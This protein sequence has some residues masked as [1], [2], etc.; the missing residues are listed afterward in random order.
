MQLLTLNKNKS[1]NLMNSSSLS[2][3]RSL[4]KNALITTSLEDSIFCQFFCLR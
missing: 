1:G 4:E 3:S 2:C